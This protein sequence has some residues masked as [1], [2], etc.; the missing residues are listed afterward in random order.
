MPLFSSGKS[1]KWNEPAAFRRARAGYEMGRPLD[2]RKRAVMTFGAMGAV[3]GISYHFMN[4]LFKHPEFLAALC[5]LALV[6]G[7]AYV[8][9]RG[10]LLANTDARIELTGGQIM[11]VAAFGL[12]KEKWEIKE[13]KDYEFLSAEGCE[14]LRITMGD[15][16]EIFFGVPRN[17]RNSSESKLRDA[18][19]AARK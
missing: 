14:V 6:I 7:I 2:L 15:G 13:M 4:E 8:P 18:F 5:I 11:R 16:S 17:A 10:W 12:E 19:A 3:V 9:M 1:A